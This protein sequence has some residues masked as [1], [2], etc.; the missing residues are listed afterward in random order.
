MPSKLS[1]SRSQRSSSSLHSPHLCHGLTC[2][3][4]QSATHP[5][6]PSRL[7]LSLR[8]GSRRLLCLPLLPVTLRHTNRLPKVPLFHLFKRLLQPS[9]QRLATQSVN[10]TYPALH[11]LPKLHRL[12]ALPQRPASIPITTIH[13]SIIRTHHCTLSSHPRRLAPRVL[14]HY[15]IRF[16]LSQI[17]H[18][19]HHIICLL[20]LRSHSRNLFLFP[21]PLTSLPTLPALPRLLRLRSLLSLSH[22]PLFRMFLHP[23]PRPAASPSTE[24]L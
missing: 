16:P 19:H 23:P 20:G 7:L 10:P 18:R 5:P 15:R 11:H 3:N 4:H 21:L 2:Q 12:L 6:L 24:L 8:K 9:I 17:R 1:P 22:S 14:Y 13:D